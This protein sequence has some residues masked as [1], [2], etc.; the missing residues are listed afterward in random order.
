MIILKIKKNKLH[1]TFYWK[2]LN[3]NKKLNYSIRF[4]TLITM[5]KTHLIKLIVHRNTYGDTG[6]LGNTIDVPTIIIIK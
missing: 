1:K 2:C 6:L 3:K 4:F 5:K